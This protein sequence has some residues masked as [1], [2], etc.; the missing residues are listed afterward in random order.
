[1]TEVQVTLELV[2]EDE[3]C[4]QQSS[5]NVHK[6][7]AG[8]FVKMGLD[9]E[10]AQYKLRNELQEYIKKDATAQQS[11]TLLDHWAVLR[12][13][14]TVFEELHLAHMPALFQFLID[15]KEDVFDSDN[16]NPEDAKL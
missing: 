14:I 11:L 2:Q 4:A 15:C 5:I 12:K 3:D 8:K 7:Q 16:N 13:S 6:T 1:M 10:D 9:L